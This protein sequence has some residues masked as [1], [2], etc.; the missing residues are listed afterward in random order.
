L[1]FANKKG[2]YAY[3]GLTIAQVNNIY[4]EMNARCDLLSR[5]CG[6]SNDG[7]SFCLGLYLGGAATYP[8]YYRYEYNNA[9][10]KGALYLHPMLS[11]VWST[12]AD[13][14]G[15]TGNVV[16]HSSTS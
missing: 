3:N 6:I 12:D 16:F 15:K 2:E 8:M 5:T 1:K 10:G 4:K 14:G 7:T 9:K 11:V 13:V